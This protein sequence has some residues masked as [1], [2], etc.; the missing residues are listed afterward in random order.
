MTQT[1]QTHTR[2]DEADMTAD[3]IAEARYQAALERKRKHQR[4]SAQEYA[5]SWAERQV[6]YGHDN[7]GEKLL[8]SWLNRLG[9]AV[10]VCE[11]TKHCGDCY[12]YGTCYYILGPHDICARCTILTFKNNGHNPRADEVAEMTNRERVERMKKNLPRDPERKHTGMEGRPVEGVRPDEFG[13]KR[14]PTE[15]QGTL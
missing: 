11:E 15:E 5:L 12:E 8:S 2:A 9:M 14:E 7:Y 1:T 6:D 10:Q 13:G 4:R 3:E